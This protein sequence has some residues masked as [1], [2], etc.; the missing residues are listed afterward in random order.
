MTL[1]GTRPAEWPVSFY[2][3]DVGPFTITITYAGDANFLPASF[4]YATSAT[5]GSATIGAAAERAGTSLLLHVSV[6]GSPAVAPTGTVTVSEPGIIP[7]VTA[8]LSGGHAD[9]TLPNVA[10]GPHT[11]A[12]S[13]A[14]DT[15][16]NPSTQNLRFTEHHRAAQH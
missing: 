15:R 9:V 6:T 7:A 8:T 3:P 2:L 11:L 1:T 12:I 14:G 10:P 13:Y 5:R 16:Y 4:S